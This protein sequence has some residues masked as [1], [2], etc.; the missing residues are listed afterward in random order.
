MEF[1]VWD[2]VFLKI[3]HKRGLMHFWHSDKLSPR[4]IG[5][6]EILDRVGVVAYRLA[7]PPRLANVH[8]V[9]HISML[10][11]YKSDLSHIL[12]W[13]DLVINEDIMYGSDRFL[14]GT[15]GT[16]FSEGRPFHW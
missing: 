4:F 1:A 2:Q 10:R 8:N 16:K 14:C 7:L 13:R 11:R 5:P 9:F 3:S 12:D 15:R 6:F